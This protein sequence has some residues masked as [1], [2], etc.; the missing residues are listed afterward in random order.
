[1]VAEGGIRSRGTGESDRSND[2]RS[3][4]PLETTEVVTTLSCSATLGEETCR[5]AR[6][7]ISCPVGTA[8]AGL[9]DSKITPC[10]YCPNMV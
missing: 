1:M 3:L 9:T 8:G 5:P 7:F 4:G 2:V 6:S 10:F